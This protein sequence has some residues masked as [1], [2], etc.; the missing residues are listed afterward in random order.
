MNPNTDSEPT[1]TEADP[2]PVPSG[3][4]LVWAKHLDQAANSCFLALSHAIG[5]PDGESSCEWVVSPLLREDRIQY[6]VRYSNENLLPDGAEKLYFDDAR[7][8]QQWCERI[9]AENGGKPL[10]YGQPEPETD[11]LALDKDRYAPTH[12][13]LAR[14]SRNG[15]VLNFYRV[16]AKPDH[17]EQTQ[18][19]ELEGDEYEAVLVNWAKQKLVSMIAQRVATGWIEP[20]ECEGPF[21]RFVLESE[22]E[23]VRCIAFTWHRPEVIRGNVSAKLR[24]ISSIV[25]FDPPTHEKVIALIAMAETKH[26]LELAKKAGDKTEEELRAEVAAHAAAAGVTGDVLPVTIEDMQAVGID[27]M[28]GVRTDA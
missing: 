21:G 14:W 2:T 11:P 25:Q 15:G 19:R 8:A 4:V 5:D 16:W 24:E 22:V 13:V 10:S 3:P 12:K 1:I 26:R 6:S 18:E 17:P 27:P 28:K 20:F 7:Q 23:F 9:E